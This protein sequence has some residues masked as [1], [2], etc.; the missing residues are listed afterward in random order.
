MKFLDA[1]IILRYLVRD[2]ESKAAKCFELF[3][4]LKENR[5]QVLTSEAILTEV[6]YVLVSKRN[7]YHL[8]HGDIRARLMPI[9]SMSGLKIPNKKRYLRALDI[10]ALYSNL[11]IEDAVIIAHM[12]AEGIKE[13]LSY[14]T[15]FDRK[16]NIK[17]TEP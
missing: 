2:D 11:D 10:F 8:S 1:N 4:A 3:Q 5:E 9:I 17:R 6:C 12:E 15:D 7:Q 16:P 13:L 14:D